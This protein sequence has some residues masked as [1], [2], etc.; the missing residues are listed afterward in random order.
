[1]AQNK[2]SFGKKKFSK[3]FS[4][5]AYGLAVS[6]I[7]LFKHGITVFVGEKHGLTG[8]QMTHG[9]GKCQILSRDTVFLFKISGI[10]VKII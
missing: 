7:S 2:I 3:T 5:G 8:F 9:D 10:S 6:G 4:V 1:M